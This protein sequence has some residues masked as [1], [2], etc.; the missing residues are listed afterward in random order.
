MKHGEKLCAS[1]PMTEFSFVA[2]FC[3]AHYAWEYRLCVNRQFGE[4]DPEVLHEEHTSLGPFD[5]MDALI[6][7]FLPGAA[8]T[9]LI[10]LSEAAQE[11]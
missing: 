8:L 6:A 1:L 10:I 11:D 3:H 9:E 5:G 4:S 7:A 2:W